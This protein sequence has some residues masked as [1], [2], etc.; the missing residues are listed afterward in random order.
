MIETDLIFVYGT[1]Q[2]GFDNRFSR[3]LTKYSQLIGI[4]NIQGKLYNLGEYPGVCPCVENSKVYGELY[5]CS[6]PERIFPVLDYY[7]G[8]QYKR[9]LAEVALQQNI[10]KAY[11]YF[12]TLPIDNDEFIISG[13]YKTFRSDL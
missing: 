13:N 9:E 4:G 1:L 8:D 7:E 6:Q 12:Y 2:Q 3:I 10:Y 5:R 11:V